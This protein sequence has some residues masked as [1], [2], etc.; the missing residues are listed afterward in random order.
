MH[1]QDLDVNLQIK[2]LQPPPPGPQNLIIPIILGFL[3]IQLNNMLQRC[4]DHYRGIIF[5]RDR[6]KNVYFHNFGPNSQIQ[7]L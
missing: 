5:N 6:T 1:F 7:F 2:I 4:L 3:H